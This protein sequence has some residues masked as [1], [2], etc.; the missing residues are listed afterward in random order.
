M[1]SAKY[2]LS[3]SC[4]AHYSARRQF[5][6]LVVYTP[7]RRFFFFAP[8]TTQMLQNKALLQFHVLQFYALHF[9]VLYFRVLH[10]QRPH[11]IRN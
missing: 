5:L 4:V 7:G 2:T 11:W 3:G 9:H 1:C 8:E 10:F 6:M